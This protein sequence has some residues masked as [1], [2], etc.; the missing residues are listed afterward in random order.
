MKIAGREYVT[1]Q[2]RNE[3]TVVAHLYRG[4]FDNVGDPMCARGWNRLDGQGYSIFRNLH[5][6][7]ICKTCTRRAKAKLPPAPRLHRKT[8]WI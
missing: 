3:P 7:R 6:V 2:D 8:K 5:D 1:G 4:A